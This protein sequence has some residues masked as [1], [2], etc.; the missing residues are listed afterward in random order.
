M[1]NVELEIIEPELVSI[2]TLS[3]IIDTPVKTLRKWVLTRRIPYRKVQGSVKFHLKE[4]RA[5]YNVRK[6]TP[7]D[8]ALPHDIH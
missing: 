8:A 3:R 5:W 1:Q 4:I 7:L 6:V 2:K